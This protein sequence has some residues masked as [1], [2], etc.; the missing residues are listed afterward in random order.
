MSTYARATRIQFPP[1]GLDRAISHFK[2]VTVPAAKALAGFA[3]TVMMVNRSTG[4]CGAVTFWDSRDNLKASEQAG[5]QLRTQAASAAGG[6]VVD[7]RR[8]EVVLREMAGPPTSGTSVRVNVGQAAP[9]KLDT[10]TQR[11][12]DEA[13]PTVRGLRGFRALNLSID[14]DTGGFAIISVWDTPAD[15]EASF[16]GI[17]DMRTRLFADINAENVDVTEYE[18]VYVEFAAVAATA[19]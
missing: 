19:E 15:R 8:Y 6:D 7:V 17:Q 5:T 12:R 3:G 16:A 10:L 4:D 11:M 18:T 14:R 9:E 13:L 1:D 2:E